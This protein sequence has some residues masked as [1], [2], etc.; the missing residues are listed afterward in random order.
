[1]ITIPQLLMYL[2]IPLFGD[3]LYFLL[4]GNEGPECGVISLIFFNIAFLSLF[5][6]YVTTSVKDSSFLKKGLSTVTGFYMVIESIL[7]FMFISLDGSER[8]AL[9]VQCLVLGLFLIIFFRIVHTN[10][11]T[12]IS[13]KEWNNS[14]SEY[15]RQSRE[16]LQ[17]AL[18]LQNDPVIREHIRETLS[19]ISSMPLQQNV[20]TDQLDKIILQKSIDISSQ[21]SLESLKDLKKI[22]A[23]RKASF[24][25]KMA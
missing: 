5:L 1:M 22:L 7:A 19:M 14:S 8:V 24:L 16:L 25:L 21:P 23:Q 12:D 15:L 20:A 6:P 17:T 18:A 11:V 13:L 4:Y 10:R 3:G 2:C 9:T